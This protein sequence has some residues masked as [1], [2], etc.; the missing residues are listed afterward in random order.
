MSVLKSYYVL[1]TRTKNKV[2]L[3]NDNKKNRSELDL[4]QRRALHPN[5]HYVITPKKKLDI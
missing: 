5:I 1:I 3:I 4:N 2:S